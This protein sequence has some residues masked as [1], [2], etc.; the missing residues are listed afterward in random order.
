MRS[1]VLKYKKNFSNTCVLVAK[2][3]TVKAELQQY[4]VP[5]LFAYYLHTQRSLDY[6]RDVDTVLSLTYTW[7][8]TDTNECEFGEC[9]VLVAID[10]FK[11]VEQ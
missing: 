6:D 3:V 4:E 11:A 2:S 7:V 9:W 5:S 1:Y 10:H 8:E